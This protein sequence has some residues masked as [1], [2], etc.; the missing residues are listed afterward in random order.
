MSEVKK[1]SQGG[2]D[3]RMKNITADEYRLWTIACRLYPDGSQEVR[4]A[5]VD[6]AISMAKNMTRSEP[7]ETPAFTSSDVE[8]LEK[9]IQDLRWQRDQYQ[10]V[11]DSWMKQYDQMVEKYEPKVLVES[12]PDAGR[13]SNT[14]GDHNIKCP[15]C[16]EPQLDPDEL[17]QEAAK[18]RGW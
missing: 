3:E 9:E 2:A 13:L 17:Y 7:K 16:G 10:M 6:G 1:P 11:A 14:G 18:K 12:S 5:W 15:K 4:Q 8:E